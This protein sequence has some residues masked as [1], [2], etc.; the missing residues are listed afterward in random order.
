M[1]VWHRDRPARTEVQGVWDVAEGTDLM[2]T[3]VLVACLVVGA[4]GGATP[5]TPQPDTHQHD[6]YAGQIAAQDAAIHALAVT[7]A[8]L[9]A[10][11]D[12]R[13]DAAT[14][15]T[16]AEWPHRFDRHEERIGNLEQAIYEGK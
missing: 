6:A 7:V 1:C 5:A 14:P 10:E 8:Q 16:P 3:A 13:P 2:R 9:R 15:A 4:C 12:A 11:L